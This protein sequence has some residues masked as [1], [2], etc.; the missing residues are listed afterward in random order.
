VTARRIKEALFP[1][2]SS[3]R[4]SPAQSVHQ[5]R[6][7]RHTE[8]QPTRILIV[9]DHETS[10]AALRGLLRTEGIDLADVR[11]GDTAITAAI[12]FQPDVVIVDV[13]PAD[14]TGFLVALRLQVRGW[15]RELHARASSVFA[16]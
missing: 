4:L 15:R 2:P 8:L 3:H 7:R 13:T 9:D 11:T 6:D 12:A 1:G 16:V 10:R 5:A 14:P